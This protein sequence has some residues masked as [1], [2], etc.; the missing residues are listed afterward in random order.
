MSRTTKI[1]LI[2]AASLVLVGLRPVCGRY[3]H[4]CMG[5]RKAFNG[6]V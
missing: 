6:P 1:W 4:A 2:T 3:V 5:F